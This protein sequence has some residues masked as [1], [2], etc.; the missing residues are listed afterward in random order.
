MNFILSFS[1]AVL[2]TESNSFQQS[3]EEAV[4]VFGLLNFTLPFLCTLDSVH[5]NDNVIYHRKI[6]SLVLINIGASIKLRKTFDC[7]L[8][9]NQ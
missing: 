2:M 4:V 6:N 9:A 8:F 7:I 1:Q 3:T 5:K